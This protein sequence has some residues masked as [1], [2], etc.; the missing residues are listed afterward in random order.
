MYAV[1]SMFLVTDCW[2]ASYVD[3]PLNSVLFC[4]PCFVKIFDDIPKEASFVVGFSY[5][6]VV[7][8]L[9]IVCLI[10]GREEIVVPPILG[11]EVIVVFLNMVWLIFGREDI[12]V[13]SIIVWFIVGR[14]YIDV[15]PIMV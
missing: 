3:L 6:Y 9:I 14:G 2:F 12:V 15:L 11:R 4:V 13:L 1:K 10:V 8:L 7:V 5:V